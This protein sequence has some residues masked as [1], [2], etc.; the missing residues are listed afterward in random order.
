MLPNDHAH[1]IVV[2]NEKGGVGK[3]TTSINIITD[4]LY[5]GHVVS[6]IDL[7]YRQRSLGTF[8]RNRAKTITTNKVSLPVPTLY[9][10]NK[11]KAD[12]LDEARDDENERFLNCLNQAAYEG[13]FVVIDAPGQDN[14][15]TRLAHS[16]ADTI[17]T[18]IN[19]SFLDFSVLADVN[20][21]TYDIDHS[22]VYSEVVW[23]AKKERMQRDNHPIDWVVLRNRLTNID[24]HNKQHMSRALE[25]LS[26]RLG[27]RIAE[28]FSERVIFRELYLKGLSLLDVLN[29][30]AGIK[31]KVSHLAARQELRNFID[32]LRLEPEIPDEV[33]FE[34]KQS[35]AELPFRE[36]SLNNEQL[37]NLSL[38]HLDDTDNK[39]SLED[40]SLERDAIEAAIPLEESIPEEAFTPTTSTESE[41]GEEAAEEFIT[42]IE[43]DGPLIHQYAEKIE[44]EADIP[45]DQNGSFYTPSIEDDNEVQDVSDF[46]TPPTP[47]TEENNFST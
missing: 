20:S 13:D 28:G 36:S 42:E 9:L 17:V 29:E 11:S 1:I 16:Y 4:L 21:D 18:P 22:G 12:S 5:D 38:G 33:S 39:F 6:A 37:T 32:F 30:K 23:E 14:H 25:K 40:L 43:E 7:D 26:K 2:G 46:E 35:E 10:L 44:G 27:C 41:I 45:R 8:M 15:L 31:P 19:D 3:T 47:P 24:A 34:E